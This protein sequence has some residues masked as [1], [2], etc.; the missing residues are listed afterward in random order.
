MTATGPRYYRI[1][2][3][4]KADYFEDTDAL[5]AAVEDYLESLELEV[6]HDKLHVYEVAP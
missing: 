3:V 4:V 6:V 5:A 2:A 1:E